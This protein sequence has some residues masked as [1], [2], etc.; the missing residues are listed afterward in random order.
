[1]RESETEEV[2]DKAYR[3]NHPRLEPDITCRGIAGDGLIQAADMSGGGSWMGPRR[4]RVDE[5]LQ[6]G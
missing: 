4:G 6:A 1:M 2:V 5:G 3:Q